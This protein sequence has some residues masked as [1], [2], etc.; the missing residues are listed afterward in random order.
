MKFYEEFHVL[1]EQ[2]G[3]VPGCR[4]EGCGAARSGHV[5]RV[6]KWQNFAIGTGVTSSESDHYVNVLSRRR[7]LSFSSLSVK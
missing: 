3:F 4:L 7:Y 1:R 6:F 5:Q 2:R